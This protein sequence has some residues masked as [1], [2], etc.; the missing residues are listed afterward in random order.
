[1]EVSSLDRKKGISSSR[2][3]FKL[4]LDHW[5]PHLLECLLKSGF[6]GL[7]LTPADSEG[8]A[9]GI[10]SNFKLSQVIRRLMFENCCRQRKKVAL[11]WGWS[12][13]DVGWRR[14][15]VQPE[16]FDELGE[17]KGG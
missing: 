1:M 3:V 17:R 13:E 16:E 4:P 15:Q 7:H 9:P 6:L 12:S 5:Y 10:C 14:K 2:P 11:V 8:G